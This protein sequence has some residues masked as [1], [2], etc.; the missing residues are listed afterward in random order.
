MNQSIAQNVTPY[1]TLPTTS[2]PASRKPVSL[3]RLLEMRARGE[4]IAGV[5]DVLRGY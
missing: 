5:V 3:P 4:K 2:S 1:G